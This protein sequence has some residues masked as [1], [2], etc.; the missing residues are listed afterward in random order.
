[1]IFDVNL[2]DNFQRKARLVT[3][4][5][6]TKILS[7]TTYSSVLYRYFAQIFLFSAILNDLGAQLGDIKN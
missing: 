2:G 1:M 7:S 3:D 5:H 4:G 6:N